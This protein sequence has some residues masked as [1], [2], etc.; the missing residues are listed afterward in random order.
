MACMQA[1][2]RTD[3]VDDVTSAWARERPDLDLSA[4]AVAGRLGRLALLLSAAED[5]TLA[6]FG[7]QDGG[8]D[9][10]AALRRSGEPTRSSLR[11][12]RSH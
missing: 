8:V 4:I 11:N 3:A 12:C 7:L 10:L 2:R 5:E 9:V 1:E 6:A